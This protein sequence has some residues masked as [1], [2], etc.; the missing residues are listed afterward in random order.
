MK[1]KLVLASALIFM[2][3]AALLAQCCGG[4]SGSPI[5]GGSSQGVLPFHQLEINSNFQYVNTNTF[6][7]GD[8]RDTGVYFDSYRSGYIYTRVGFG[9]TKDFTMSV[10]TGFWTN[11]TEIALNNSDTVSSK[12]IGDL[13]L[14]PKYDI[15]NKKCASSNF[16][17]TVGLGYKIPLGKYNDSVAWVEPFSGNTYYFTKP[18]AVQT[19]SGSNDFIFYTGIYKG[20]TKT[21]FRFFANATY[22]RKGWNPIGEKLGDFASVGL[23]ASRTF[24]E[25]L[26]VTVQLRGEWIDHMKLNETV[27]LYAYPNY[28]PEATGSKKVF[29][30]PQLSYTFAQKIT[31]Y[32]LADLP[33]YQ[34]ATG[35]QPGS[36]LQVTAGI[37]LRLFGKKECTPEN[38][39]STATYYCPM[40]CEGKEK[41]YTEPGSCPVCGMD[42]VK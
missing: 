36:E 31:V 29:F 38:S 34:Y 4:G 25:K 15:I 41:V 14:F 42:L 12:G 5:A 26:G 7:Q 18:M 8:S 2:Q 32:A 23:F 3:S 35:N 10:E 16:E 1:R 11:K 13:I 19:S 37:A 28:N 6:F 27:L 17:W 40:H 21:Q 20:Y 22:I 24:F 30:C 9:V 39:D 33:V